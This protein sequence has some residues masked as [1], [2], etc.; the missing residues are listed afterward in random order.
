MRNDGW[1]PLQLRH[2]G[3]YID[4]QQPWHTSLQQWPSSIATLA[5][6]ANWTQE[7]SLNGFSK[8]RQ[9]TEPTVPLETIVHAVHQAAIFEEP[10]NPVTTHS[11]VNGV[12]GT[13]N[14]AWGC[15]LCRKHAHE[16]EKLMTEP[17]ET[18][19]WVGEW[20][21]APWEESRKRQGIQ[22]PAD[23]SILMD[24]L[25]AD[26]SIIHSI[27]LAHFWT[28]HLCWKGI[29]RGKSFLRD[30]CVSRDMCVRDELISG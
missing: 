1:M 24:E 9:P 22:R 5:L 11:S 2:K 6:L 26:H 8:K 3:S 7:I 13:A 15:T 25:Q 21:G 10:S 23:C 20:R 14:D 28:R 12:E 17:L 30:I 27:V 18:F 29:K 16:D 19:R 4:I